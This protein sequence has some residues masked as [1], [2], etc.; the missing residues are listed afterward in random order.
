M[1][2]RAT[3]EPALERSE[4]WRGNLYLDKIFEDS[5]VPSTLCVMRLLRR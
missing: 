2:L 3:E 1:S 4:G 5:P